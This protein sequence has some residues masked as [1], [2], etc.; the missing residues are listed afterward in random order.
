M[1]S[2]GHRLGLG[3][4]GSH[5]WGR[6]GHVLATGPGL[7]RLPPLTASLAPRQELEEQLE[8]E[9]SARQKLQLEKVTTEA[10]LKKLEEDQIIME[11]QN[12]KLAKVRP[13]RWRR[14]PAALQLLLSQG[15]GCPSAAPCSKG[16]LSQR[17]GAQGE[18]L[19]PVLSKALR[20]LPRPAAEPSVG[21]RASVTGGLCARWWLSVVARVPSASRLQGGGGFSRNQV[22]SLSESAGD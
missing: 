6:A 10:K 18:G 8:E 7:H 15:R 13:E 4:E 11:D 12:C 2:Q 9:E 1:R 3:S 17:S 20:R 14:R 5:D 16:C 22:G 21:F 19:A